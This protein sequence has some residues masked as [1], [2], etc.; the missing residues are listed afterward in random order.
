MVRVHRRIGIQIWRRNIFQ[1][2][3]RAR[4]TNGNVF[5]N[6]FLFLTNDLLEELSLVSFRCPSTLRMLA[7]FTRSR[8]FLRREKEENSRW[9]E[10]WVRTDKEGWRRE[11]FPG[12][13]FLF[14]GSAMK[15]FAIFRE[16]R[17]RSD[18]TDGSSNSACLCVCS[19]T[20]ET[21]ERVPRA[22]KRGGGEACGGIASLC[23]MEKLYYFLDSRIFARLSIHYTC[24]IHTLTHTHAHIYI[25]HAI[26]INFRSTEESWKKNVKK[27]KKKILVSHS[28][29][30]I[31]EW[32]LKA[33]RRVKLQSKG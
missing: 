5:S 13:T 28:I 18:N 6:F 32:M 9:S 19:S 25:Y 11:S 10:G 4:Q 24:Y 22:T 1:Q 3:A 30:F 12:K 31:V 7:R 26:L 15:L 29:V 21:R 17:R 20:C 23:K 27:R 33:K 8:G 2:L 14:F 16:G